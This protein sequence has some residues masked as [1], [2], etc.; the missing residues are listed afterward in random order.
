MSNA[1]K[2]SGGADGT[3]II[4]LL[5]RIFERFLF[6]FNELRKYKNNRLSDGSRTLEN[7]YLDFSV[8]YENGNLA[9]IVK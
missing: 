9:T 8:L 5:L 7:L 1:E 4:T 3:Y 2:L 6:C